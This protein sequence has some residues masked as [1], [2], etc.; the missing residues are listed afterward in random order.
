M[1]ILVN[2]IM[3][4]TAIFISI[5]AAC[6]V[7]SSICLGGDFFNPNALPVHYASIALMLLAMAKKGMYSFA[8]PMAMFGTFN[9]LAFPLT[10]CLAPSSG[11]ASLSAVFYLAIEPIFVLVGFLVGIYLDRTTE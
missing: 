11:G 3:L 7:L 8:M 4:R 10:G 1:K 2:R 6:L 9:V 5:F